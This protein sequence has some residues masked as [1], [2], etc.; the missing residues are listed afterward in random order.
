MPVNYFRSTVSCATNV[1][2][3][4]VLM[5]IQANELKPEVYTIST[6]SICFYHWSPV[7]DDMERCSR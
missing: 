6:F 5:M 4:F 7:A 3:I 1:S 2:R